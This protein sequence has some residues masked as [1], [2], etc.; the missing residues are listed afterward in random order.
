LL[1][2]LHLKAHNVAA[3]DQ[4][5]KCPPKAACHLPI[6]HVQ[7]VLQLAAIGRTLKAKEHDLDDLVLMSHEAN[8]A[9][10]IAKADLARVSPGLHPSK[11][12]CSSR[13]LSYVDKALLLVSVR[14]PL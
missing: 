1:S 2:Y 9:K 13:N 3:F 10:E 12:I 14:I 4:P 6:D 7:L 8:H 11:R 5:F